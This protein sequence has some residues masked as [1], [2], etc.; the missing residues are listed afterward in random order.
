[1]PQSPRLAQFALFDFL[2]WTPFW[3]V[4]LIVEVRP[5]ASVLAEDAVTGVAVSALLAALAHAFGRFRRYAT[6]LLG[7][8][9]WLG[10]AGFVAYAILGA[11]QING[12]GL[13]DAS[14]Y[15]ATGARGLRLVTGYGEVAGWLLVLSLPFAALVYFWRRLAGP[16]R[17]AYLAALFVIF[18][19]PLPAKLVN[20]SLNSCDQTWDLPGHLYPVHHFRP[21]NTYFALQDLHALSVQLDNSPALPPPQVTAADRKPL[22]LIVLVGETF[23]R[24]HMSLY[25]YCRSTTPHLMA[26]GDQL[27][28]FSDLISPMPLTAAAVPNSL[29]L[30][31]M[32]QGKTDASLLPV[33][34]A[35]GFDTSWI[36]NQANVTSPP[37]SVMRLAMPARHHVWL[38]SFEALT[39]ADPP[40]GV[41]L[42]PLARALADKAP[43]KA[44]FLH[45]MG[46]HILYADRV[47]P[48]AMLPALP[49]F[50]ATR[51]GAQTASI[52]A[53]D[54][55]IQ[56][57][58]D[59]FA[60]VIAQASRQ[61][62]DA[63][64]VIYG[65]HG[66]ENFDQVS[67]QGHGWPDSTRGM[68]ETPLLVWLSPSL[69]QHR[70][71]L[72]AALSRAVREKLEISDIAPVI[73]DI[74]GLEVA[75]LAADARPLSASFLP[76]RRMVAAHDYDADHNIGVVPT[77]PPLCGPGR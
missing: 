67:F 52:N 18:L 24:N 71:D 17:P 66:E 6:L 74:A 56:Y 76:V 61:G 50:P 11:G 32:P 64:V 27:Y 9:V 20:C 29:R 26:L 53:Y 60:A 3:L 48:D 39:V 47:P 58:D 36:S 31:R 19:L 37:N 35:G 33:L 22:T 8:A 77:L 23:N 28:A 43:R 14:N 45:M 7:L 65:D 34:N 73:V 25:G 2:F 38:N 63:A 1:M 75:G 10:S 72:V 51:T 21:L 70:P 16:V 12:Y 46:A 55:A 13:F 42:A 40:D 49:P 15:A 57:D 59:L 44:I 62:G 4:P 5:L 54:R 69:R 30:L 41:M 68:V